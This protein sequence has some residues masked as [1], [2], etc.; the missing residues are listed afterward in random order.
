MITI[1]IQYDRTWI[2]Q[3]SPL[4]R[5]MFAHRVYRSN[6]CEVSFEDN[7]IVLY[8]YYETEDKIRQT[9]MITGIGIESMNIKILL[10][11]IFLFKQIM[12]ED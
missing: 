9:L 7:W 2:T 8:A 12:T 1:L 6:Y 11:L 4:H 5:S 3:Y 10:S